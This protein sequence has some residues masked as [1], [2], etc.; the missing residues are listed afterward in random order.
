MD[1]YARLEQIGIRLPPMGPRSGHFQQGREFGSN[2]L[3]MS[4][5]GPEMQDGQFVYVGRL[6]EAFTVEQGALAARSVGVTM[7]AALHA[8]TGDLNRIKRI[9]KVL[10]FVSSAPEFCQQPAVMNGF[11]DLMLEVFGPDVG[12]HARSAIGTS[13]LPSNIPVEVEMLVELQPR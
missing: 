1:I 6:G 13:V 10:G 3:Y 11:S 2:L 4:G 7:L 9:V 12:S 8:V 5:V